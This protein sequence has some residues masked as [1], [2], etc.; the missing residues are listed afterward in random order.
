MPKGQEKALFEPEV[1]RWYALLSGAT[2]KTMVSVPGVGP[3]ASCAASHPLPLIYYLNEKRDFQ[4]KIYY[5]AVGFESGWVTF[6]ELEN[7]EDTRP[8]LDGST[9]APLNKIYLAALLELGAKSDREREVEVETEILRVNG[10]HFDSYFRRAAAYRVLRNYQ[11]A[12]SDLTDALRFQPSSIDALLFRA[13]INARL[14]RPLLTRADLIHVL[15]LDPT[16]R[17]AATGL[18]VLEIQTFDKNPTP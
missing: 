11:R 1:D 18:A 17:E 5:W 12:L 15:R 7:P 3:V 14:K 8:R 10:G 6:E 9:F 16:N 2:L 4:G 13:E